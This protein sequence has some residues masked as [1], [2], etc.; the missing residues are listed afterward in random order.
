MKRSAFYHHF[1]MDEF[2][3]LFIKNFLSVDRFPSTSELDE[4]T[5]GLKEGP[6]LI[7]RL[8]SLLVRDFEIIRDVPANGMLMLLMGGTPNKHTTVAL[9]RLYHSFD[10][11][12]VPLL[13]E[14]MDGWNREPVPPLSTLDIAVMFNTIAEGMTLRAR[15]DPERARP[16]L[17]VTSIMCLI[18]TLTR[19]RGEQI[20]VDDRVAIIDSF[21]DDSDS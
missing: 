12:L 8:R 15:F 19:E 20:T 5:R 7:E 2:I 16:E 11:N 4:E 14:V 9:R 10:D 13:N 17:Y 6:D 1:N 18:A 21:T 3:P